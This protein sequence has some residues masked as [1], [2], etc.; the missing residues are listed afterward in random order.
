M[1]SFHLAE[2]GST[3]DEARALIDKG[4]KPPFYLFSDRQL[5]GRG[6]YGKSWESFEGN[7]FLSVA[8]PKESVKAPKLLSLTV[9]IA[10]A[11]ALA[12]NGLQPNLVWPNDVLIDGAKTGGILVE[13]H[14]GAFI[15]GIGLNLNSPAAPMRLE[16]GRLI[17]SVAFH[18]GAREETSLWAELL[19]EEI[20]KRIE[21]GEEAVLPLWRGFSQAHKSG[22]DQK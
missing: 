15:A 7:L 16:D 4:E 3:M 12:N 11:E 22:E 2:C 18:T 6:Q 9:G 5:N 8:V 13:E 17:A 19:A 21:L 1:R 20:A 10:A 14:G